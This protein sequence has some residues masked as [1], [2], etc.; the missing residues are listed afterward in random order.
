MTQ[1]AQYERS[2]NFTDT[3]LEAELDAIATTFGTLLTN[4]A[5]IQRDDTALADDI[6]APHTL[7]PITL[8]LFAAAFD[9][10]GA[11]ATATAYVQR[12]AVTESGNLYICAV[13][14]TS[15]TFATDLAA[16]RWMLVGNS[17]AVSSVFGRSGAI[18]AAISDY[19]AS[20]VDN[21]SAVSG[22]RVSDALNT[23]STGKQAVNANLTA[24][25]GLTGAANKLAYFT[26]A[27]ALALNDLTAFA[28][29]LID[30]SDSA[31]A[32]A[33]LE[34]SGGLTGSILAPHKTLAVNTTAVTT[35]TI[36]A[37]AIVLANS[38]GD[39]KTVSSV[40][41]SLDITTSGIGGLDTGSEA[42]STWYHIWVIAKEDGTTDAL[43]S[44]SSSSPTLPSGY[45]FKGYVGAVYND[46]SGDLVGM[47]QV[48]NL[49]AT[50]NGTPLS[51]GSATT[52][53]SV[54][55]AAMVPATARALKCSLS[56]QDTGGT[57]RSGNV[58]SH[59]TLLHSTL[60]T[61]PG[62]A[63]TAVGVPA[64]IPLTTAQTVWYNVGGATGRLTITSYGWE[65]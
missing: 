7:S 39:E 52:L 60:V 17:T 61:N 65:F 29:S 42:N 26:G 15:G 53:T 45:T 31:A 27:G 28:R 8:A 35:L 44:A 32:R 24:L 51:A 34:I 41:E 11:W 49:V 21:D 22:S 5:L 40:S 2:Y 38:S 50:E 9:P 20:Q 25:A 10:K 37:D 43:L 33:T 62:G 47:R 13:A 19:D 59:S 36:T 18:T 1:P 64:T 48:G 46:S 30:D 63:T 12:D 55:L 3:N 6:V 54:S 58:S 56:L 57:V 16:G 14:H 23:L 4:L